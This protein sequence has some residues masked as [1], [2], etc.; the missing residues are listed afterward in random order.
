MALT[1][2]GMD[3]ISRSLFMPIMLMIDFGMFQYLVSVYYVRRHER[4]VQ[5]L[6]LASF[7]GFASHVY[8]HEDKETMLSFNDISEVCSQLTF[9]IQITIIGHAVRAKVKLRS[10]TVFT[11]IAECFIVLDWLNMLASAIEAAGYELAD[12][13]HIASNVLESLTMT[14]VPVFRFYYLSLSNGFRKVLEAR[15]LEMFLYFL[16]ATHEDVMVVIEHLTGVSWEYVQGVYMRGTIA[17]CILLN[18]HKKIKQS[19][20]N[21]RGA[22]SGIPSTG[23]DSGAHSPRSFNAVVPMSS[24]VVTSIRST[25]NKGVKSVVSGRSVKSARSSSNI[26]KI[27][28]TGP[29]PPTIR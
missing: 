13:M 3:A 12:E 26:M 10:I 14:F 21:T 6:L 25:L 28:V 22:T 1:Q 5:M 4:R 9:L 23:E 2:E 16:V 17:I 18:L 29:A 27:G 20:A 24:T 19:S 7:I 8:F 15:K 11:Y